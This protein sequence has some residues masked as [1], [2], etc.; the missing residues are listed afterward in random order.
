MC[1]G[2]D[3]AVLSSSFI[4]GAGA[5]ENAESESRERGFLSLCGPFYLQCCDSLLNLVLVQTLPHP[6]WDGGWKARR[7]DGYDLGPLLWTMFLC[8]KDLTGKITC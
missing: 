8:H 5:N 6:L 7:Q 2:P 1:S 3:T 4:D